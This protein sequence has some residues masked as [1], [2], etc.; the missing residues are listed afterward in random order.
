MDYFIKVTSFIYKYKFI[1]EQRLDDG[2]I[3]IGRMPHIAPHAWLHNIYPVLNDNE[4]L[5]IQK[6]IGG[7]IPKSYTNFLILHSNGISIFND[8][9][10]LDG[11]RKKAGRSIEAAWQPYSIF[12]PNI[13]ERIRDAKPHHFFI[14]GYGWDGSLL[15]IDANTEKVYRCSRTSIKPLNSWNSFGD[16][17]VSETERI[18]LLFDENGVEKDEEKPTTP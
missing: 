12:T 13:V 11:L 9:L 16:M 2:T 4:M 15:Y 5:L 10:S 6:K 14:G 1:G 3:L 7:V 18:A 8:A 17:L